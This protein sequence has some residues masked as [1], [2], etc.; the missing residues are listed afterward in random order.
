MKSPHGR[1]SEGLVARRV[2]GIY[3]SD[4]GRTLHAE[5]YKIRRIRHGAAFGIHDCCRDVHELVALIING[6]SHT[7]RL[8]GGAYAA[9][10]ASIS[11]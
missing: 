6:K 4:T 8:P 10:Q 11:L 5:T 9:L 7:L 2:A 1:A 3:S